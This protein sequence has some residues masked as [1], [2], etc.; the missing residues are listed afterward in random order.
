[1][2]VAEYLMRVAGYFRICTK[3]EDFKFQHTAC[4]MTKT[5][6]FHSIPMTANLSNT[7]YLQRYSLKEEKNNS[8]KW[9]YT[10]YF[11]S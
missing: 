2:R 8:L 9:W 6:K 4:D 11:R 1:M 7:W 10:I 3:L 5:P